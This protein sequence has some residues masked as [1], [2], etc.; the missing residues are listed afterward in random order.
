M[1]WNTLLCKKCESEQIVKNGIVAGRQRYKC[2][3]C[4]YNF[5]EGDNRTNEGIAA[6]KALC[7]LLYTLGKGSFRMMGRILDVDHVQVY[8]WIREFSALLPEPDVPLDIKHMEFDEMW[9]FVGSKKTDFG[10]SK[11]LTV[12]AGEPW[13][14]YSAIVILQ[15]SNDSTKRLSI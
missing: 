3:K 2:K 14:G 15:H 9:H 5:R 10:L 1:G 6:K 12:V 13:R 11:Q 4:N 7:L 8:R